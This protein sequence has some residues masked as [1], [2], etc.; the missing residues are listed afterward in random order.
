MW[1]TDCLE[2]IRPITDEIILVDTGSNDR[3]CAIGERYGAKIFHFTWQD[4][5]A[6]ARNFSLE[7]A[8]GNWILVLDAD[9][10][11]SSRDFSELRKITENPATEPIAYQLLTRNY[12]NLNNIVGWQAND[13][14][15]PDAERG[16]GWI[17]SLKTRLWSNHPKIK[18][19]Y[20]V[21]EVVEP[22]LDK[23]GIKAQ[24]CPIIIH[25]YGKLDQQNTLAK[26]E[27]YFKLGLQ[28]LEQMQDA[29]IPLRELAI[30]AGI[31]QR[32]QD[33]VNL[34]NRF[35]K[36]E[37]DNPEAHL[38]LGSAYFATG[39]TKK[40]LAEARKTTALAPEIKEGHYNCSLYEL[41]LGR[42]AAAAKRLQK[43]T[44]QTPEYQ[45]ARFLYA[46]A[47][48]C[49]DGI[50]KGRRAFHDIQ[51]NTLSKEIIAIAGGELADT[52][53]RAG[54]SKEAVKIKKATSN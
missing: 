34:W 50:K 12:I 26:G 48:C 6:A 24:P 21:H 31:L 33:A 22:S 2:S 53:T 9:E 37:P 11:I 7:Q 25:H 23:I 3:T 45:A 20:P 27:E 16:C 49:R 39:E 46:A 15:F 43:L 30:Q 42:A 51:D 44:R 41:H 17:P 14:S 54:R 35:L 18:F 8:A 19:S 1:L 32:Y 38:N 52:L 5:F 4:D 47:L 13:D 29:V 36:L 28:K 10:V 40:A